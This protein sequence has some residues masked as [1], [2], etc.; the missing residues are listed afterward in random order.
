MKKQILGLSSDKR[1]FVRQP[2]AGVQFDFDLQQML[3]V[4]LVLLKEDENLNKMRFEIVP[5]L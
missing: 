5:K 3:P 4:C 2:P 1:N